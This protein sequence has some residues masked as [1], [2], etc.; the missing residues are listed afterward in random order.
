MSFAL[1]FNTL[2]HFCTNFRLIMRW[3]EDHAQAS[4]GNA[5]SIH[6]GMAPDAP[7][8]FNRETGVGEGLAVPE[9]DREVNKKPIHYRIKE[10]I[11]A[12]P[13]LDENGQAV[14]EN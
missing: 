12:I 4:R 14:D 5:R 10:A 7:M 8:T 1:V 2:I 13:I 9:A 6:V 3:Y 11:Q